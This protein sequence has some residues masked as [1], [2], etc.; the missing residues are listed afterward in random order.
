MNQEKHIARDHNT[1]NKKVHELVIRQTRELL[2]THIF[3]KSLLSS[4][5]VALIAADMQGLIK[6]FNRSAE[7]LL[8]INSVDALST[9]ITEVL[10]GNPSIIRDMNITLCNGRPVQTSSAT[11][12]LRS[13]PDIHA[14]IYIQ[15]IFND[16][17]KQCGIVVSLEDVTHYN[18]VHQALKQ[19]VPDSI[20]EEIARNPKKISLG[21]EIRNL[22]VLFTDLIGYSTLSE[23]M[24]P[25][26]IITLLSNYFGKMT[27]EIFRN[28]GTL[29]EY[30]GDGI[31]AFFGA[32]TD[33]GNH[34]VK[35]CDTALSMQKKLSTFKNPVLKS[36]IGINTGDMLVGNIGSKHRF[37]YGV[38]GDHV[39]LA[40]RIET[41]CGVYGV[42]ILISESTAL[43]V[44]HDYD[45]RELDHV[46]V[47]GRKKSVKL[48]EL[49]S[50]KRTKKKYHCR[51]N[52]YADAL[53]EYKSG[54][55]FTAGKLFS[56]ITRRYPGDHPAHL[57]KHR[58]FMFANNLPAPGSWNGIYDFNQNP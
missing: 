24:S 35:A 48:F 5:P 52:L 10:K 8:K 44:N 14:N 2:N 25:D 28:K 34:A 46:R 29:K 42:R 54:H 36:R 50:K 9:N 57:M 31:M 33:I 56:E 23:Q 6:T 3:T 22:S 38:I 43:E 17:K 55:F 32:P 20:S 26:K 53:N 21:G 13:D 58:C 1:F 51:N 11:I 45:L 15:P 12:H 30:T 40:S 41:L 37:S 49:I 4:L 39:N 16:E 47:R 19:Y 7:T 18:F 27:D